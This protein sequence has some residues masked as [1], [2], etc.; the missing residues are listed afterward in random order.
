MIPEDIEDRALMFGYCNELCGENG[1]D[2]SRRVMMLHP[3]LSHSQSEESARAF[4]SYLGGKY[5]DSRT[6]AEAALERTLSEGVA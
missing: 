6:V 4:A 2:W 1:F 5:S 3:T